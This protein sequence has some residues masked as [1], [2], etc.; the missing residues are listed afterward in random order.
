ME[1]PKSIKFNFLMNSILTISSLIFPLIT[2]PYVSR[3]LLPVGTGKISF[4]SSIISYIVMIAQLGIPTY[5]IR[6][7]AK[8]KD[9]REKLSETV[10]EI[11][12]INLFMSFISYALLLIL[13]CSVPKINQE[14]SL[15]LIMGS[16]VFF[17]AVGMEWLYKA[18][19]QYRYI[20]VRSLIF[21]V[22]AIIA[23]FLFVHSEQDYVVYG[24]ISMFA[25]SASYVLNFINVRK[26]VDLKLS[27]NNR[28]KVHMKPICVFFAMS[29]A[30]MIYG[31]MDAV[32]I[33]FFNSDADVGYYNAAVS[34]KNIMVSLVTSLGAVLLP[35]AS[36][37]VE[38]KMMAEF[39]AITRKAIG[40][41]FY[42]ATP[43]VVYFVMFAKEGILLLS[44][45]TYVPS[46]VPMKILMPTLLF[47]GLTN[48]MGIQIL[49][50]FGKEKI[51]LY[52]GVVGA[53]VNLGINFM[54]IPSMAS[55]GAAI[56]T[57]I[58][59]LSVLIVQFVY[60]RSTMNEAL[61]NI[62]F[63]PIISGTV[64]GAALSVWVSSFIETPFLI[65]LISVLVFFGIYGTALLI[66]RVPL[67]MEIVVQ[68]KLLLR[69]NSK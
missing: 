52:S 36:Y 39:Y 10:S 27:V 49:I 23:M 3:T 29:F 67:A 12:T 1:K 46:I 26:Y 68:T 28:F 64:I 63:R 33:G 19:E 57:L 21:K 53:L 2:F 13:I 54:L 5:G 25:T 4:A 20:T 44:G 16:T 41:V 60:L 47:I 18:L 55:T 69:K 15:F 65:L 42:V 58:A 35:R 31:H 14:K 9:N 61:K 7:C 30:T 48:I 34:I 22:V 56:G 32:M 62:D 45:N 37:Y 66:F 6:A 43:I 11:F 51:V 8:V 24:A 40:F 50:P 38:R 17:S 59:E